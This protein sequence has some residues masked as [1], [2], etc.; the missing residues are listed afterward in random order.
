[1]FGIKSRIIRNKYKL[2]GKKV[3]KNTVNLEWWDEKENLGD[4]LSKVVYEWMITRNNIKPELNTRKTIHFLGI[5]SVLGMAPFDATVW[6]SGVHTLESIRMILDRRK[7]LKYDI[8]CVRG[9]ITRNILVGAGYDC[10]K[11][12]GDPAIL[13]PYIYNSPIEKKE[14]DISLVEHLSQK[15]NNEIN[16]INYIDIT[17][18]DYRYF[19]DQIV[20]SKKVI[21]SSLHGIILA[22]T[23]GVPA[24]FLAKGMDNELMKFYD[25]YF[26]TGRSNVKMALTLEE[27]I[28]M[29]PME[30]PN[31]KEMQQ[32]VLKAFPYD[33]WK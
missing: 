16:N 27:A 32:N 19:I 15:N 13:L 5:G 18:H 3:K 24:V 1:M 21:S 28:Q 23:Y 11:V 2:N 4:Y 26:S 6:G 10:P 20:K 25:W 9:P 14:Y 8:R 33:L 29:T 17:T 31:L 22:E 30:L 12:Y 7:Y